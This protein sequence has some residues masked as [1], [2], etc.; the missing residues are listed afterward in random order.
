M[1][2]KRRPVNLHLPFSSGFCPASSESSLL[3][4]KGAPPY[5]HM[6]E[7]LCY[8]T[9]YFRTMQDKNL[10]KKGDADSQAFAFLSSLYGYFS[11]GA[12]AAAEG[13]GY[14]FNISVFSDFL[15]T[16]ASQCAR[17]EVSV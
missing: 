9:D 12:L 10:M 14:L 4:N 15:K 5:A 17:R 7:L 6:E 3:N 16:A 13:G 11:S 1:T 8:L 2:E